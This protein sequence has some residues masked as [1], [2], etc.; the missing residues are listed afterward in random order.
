[1]V[2]SSEDAI[3]S[4]DI[5]GIVTTWNKGA[6]RLFGYT[7]DEMVGKPVTSLIPSDRHGE[8]RAIL[9]RISRGEQIESYET[10][11]RRKD[12]SLVDVSLTISPVR[13]AEGKIVGASKIA[14]DITRRKRAERREKTLMSELDH[15]VRNSLARVAMVATS[16]RHDSN[17]IDE[18]ARS[19][20]GRIH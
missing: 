10:V 3:I 8:E 5:A 1:I 4:K 18:F 9:E 19:L 15:R 12:G 16:S 13:N 14:R 11:R 20:D 17:S 7:S 2:E 6:E